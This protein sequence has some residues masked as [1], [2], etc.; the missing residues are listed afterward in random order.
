MPSLTVT[1]TTAPNDAVRLLIA[2][3]EEV[4]SAE[5]PA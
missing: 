2:E 4:L 3:L 5:Y 1:L